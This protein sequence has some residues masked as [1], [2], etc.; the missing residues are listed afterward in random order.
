MRPKTIIGIVLIVVFTGFL[1]MNFGQQVGGYMNFSQAMESGSRAH[2]VGDWVEER[3]FEY[4]P[5]ANVFSFHMQDDQ[6]TIRKIRYNHPKPPNFED[7]EKIVVEGRV[8]NEIFVADKILIKCPS[9][10]QGVKGLDLVPDLTR[11]SLDP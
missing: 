9:K 4:D 7:A 6:G 3:A 8:E 10:Y 11:E 2:V 1:L 5:Q